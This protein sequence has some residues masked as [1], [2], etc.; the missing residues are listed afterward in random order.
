[1]MRGSS[2]AVGFSLPAASRR[3][4][5]DYV[6]GY[7]CVSVCLC[8]VNVGKQDIIS[9][10]N[11]SIFAKFI[12]N[13]HHVL[14]GET[15]TSGTDHDQ[16]GAERL[17]SRESHYTECQLLRPISTSVTAPLVTKGRRFLTPDRLSVNQAVASRIKIKRFL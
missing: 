1:M 3:A 10:T 9:K 13:T 16:G 11:S 8:V 2:K 7:I 15:I 4:A 12:T 17:A 5:A 6:L 14:P